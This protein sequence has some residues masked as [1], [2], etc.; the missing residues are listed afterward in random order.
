VSSAPRRSRI[1]VGLSTTV[2]AVAAVTACGTESAGD[3]GSQPS[4]SAPSS[5]ASTPA[6][7]TPARPH[8]TPSTDCPQ[9]IK[10]VQ[11]DLEKATW[12]KGMK[13]AEFTPVSVTICQYDAEAAGDAYASVQTKRTQTGST[14]LFTMVNAA[15]PVETKP[16]ICTKEL[17]PTYVL[18]FTDNER[19]VLTYAA[20]G[21]GCRRLV[22]TSF[23]GDGKPQGLA[24]PRQVTPQLLKT[25]GL[26]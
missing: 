26:R 11:Q 22:A 19:G 15:D 10:A 5:S 3:P 20:E 23:E 12:G 24:A 21:F 6:P 25:L 4:P 18:R 1:I 8:G 14:Q 17:G 13:K 7:S 2:A 9:P 16:K